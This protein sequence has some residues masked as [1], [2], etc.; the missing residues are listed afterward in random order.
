MK[1]VVIGIL[2][3]PF[4][5]FILIGMLVFSFFHG[6]GV[7]TIDAWTSKKDE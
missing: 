2:I 5:P 7:I 6:L 1:E 4:V 3:L